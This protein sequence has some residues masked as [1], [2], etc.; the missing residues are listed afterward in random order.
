M[1]TGALAESKSYT[2]RPG[3]CWDSI[4][5]ST[6]LRS[7]VALNERCWKLS[8]VPP[9]KQYVLQMMFFNLKID[10]S[11][12]WSHLSSALSQCRQLHYGFPLMQSH[13][14]EFPQFKHGPNALGKSFSIPIAFSCQIDK[15]LPVC[16]GWGTMP[17]H[18][19]FS[20]QITWG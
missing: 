13:C 19:S 11:G 12:I 14:R 20:F 1:T 2:I 3:F 6:G 5:S 15:V 16:L 7:G 10:S 17:H 18:F 9:L 4:W 8:P